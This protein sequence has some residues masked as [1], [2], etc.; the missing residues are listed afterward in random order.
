MASLIDMAAG[1]IHES[2]MSSTAYNDPMYRQLQGFTAQDT[3]IGGN[4]NY[5]GKGA[6]EQ[7][8]KQT[9]KV[10]NI[11]D[12][13][14]DRV[15]SLRGLHLAKSIKNSIVNDCFHSLCDKSIVDIQYRT[16]NKKL[17]KLFNDD[18]KSLLKRTAFLDIFK[19]CLTNDGMNYGEMFIGTTCKI[20]EGII[21]ISDCIGTRN[22]LAIYKNLTPIGFIK[23]KKRNNESTPE[24]YIS[25]EKISHFIVNPEKID[26]EIVIDLDTDIEIPEKIMCATPLLDPVVELII[27]YNAL[28]RLSTGVEL[29]K[30]MAPTVLAVGVSANSDMAEITRQLQQY[31]ISLNASRNNILNN[32]NN[33]DVK[34]ISKDIGKIQLIPY[35]I[36]EGTN[37]MKQIVIDKSDSKLPEL[38]ND[39]CKIIARAMGMPESYLASTT[40]Q[41]KKEENIAMNP[42]YSRMLSGIQQSLAMGIRDFV[43]KHLEYKYTKYD[44][45][46]KSYLTRKIDRDEIEVKFQSITNIDN[47]LDMEQMMLTAETMGNIAGVLDV[48]TGS[49]NLPVKT[50][51]VAFMKLWA[52]L[53][54]SVVPL[55]D[56]LEI[57]DAL[58]EQ[59]DMSNTLND[60]TDLEGT[61]VNVDSEDNP[62]LTDTV[63]KEKEN[64][65]TKSK[66]KEKEKD[67]KEI[68]H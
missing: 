49:P 19:N 51:G 56:S 14:F 45:D 64:T 12:V 31:S 39:K 22:H 11:R 66:P 8:N 42:R 5:Y 53:T 4:S 68:F 40:L 37:S 32:L 50:N 59:N 13:L 9:E 20:G 48:I 55:R 21:E 62:S 58:D 23:F 7:V 43:Y 33:L 67:V 63:D 60:E 24:D 36:E 65:K 6:Q 47:R 17:F 54:E 52:K 28:E 29:C 10:K 27:E 57:D 46:G 15:D 18:I 16:E 44:K 25:S 61:D 34:T 3:E 26:L 1:F 30:A 38:L 2:S 35:A 41:G